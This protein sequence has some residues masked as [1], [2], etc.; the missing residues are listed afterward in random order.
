M[1]VHERYREEGVE[2]DAYFESGKDFKK[3]K[4]EMFDKERKIAMYAERTRL[5]KA[6]KEDEVND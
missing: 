4:Q 5:Y 6:R 2:R 3:R 1:T